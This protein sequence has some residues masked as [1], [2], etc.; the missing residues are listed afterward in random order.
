MLITLEIRLQTLGAVVKTHLHCSKSFNPTRWWARCRSRLSLNLSESKRRWRR[1]LFTSSNPRFGK[2]M[3]ERPLITCGP[4]ATQGAQSG[5]ALSQNWQ[6]GYCHGF[7]ESHILCPCL[8]SPVVSFNFFVIW[9]DDPSGGVM[10]GKRGL[11][12]LGSQNSQNT[13][14]YCTVAWWLLHN[15]RKSALERWRMWARSGF[16]GHTRLHA[17]YCWCIYTQ[18]F[19]RGWQVVPFF[20]NR[21]GS[22]DLK[23]IV[24][25][26]D[27]TS[28]IGLATFTRNQQV[29]TSVNA[30]VDVYW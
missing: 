3:Y 12:Y 14:V 11:S 20:S 23:C 30:W 16:K 21:A 18:V 19:P 28:W 17:A 22:A 27:V 8:T 29:E 25:E 26:S 2:L 1:D 7:S 9:G 5:A 24:V 6:H 13:V 10:L 15:K 4:N